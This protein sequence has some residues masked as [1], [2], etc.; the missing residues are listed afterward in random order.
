MNK[1]KNETFVYAT[2]V[3]ILFIAM[4]LALFGCENPNKKMIVT[5]EKETFEAVRI[6]YLPE[7]KILKVYES[8]TNGVEIFLEQVK[9]LR[10]EVEK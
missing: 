8:E 4:M 9:T 1:I 5:A 6:D 2:I 3:L 10:I 7:S